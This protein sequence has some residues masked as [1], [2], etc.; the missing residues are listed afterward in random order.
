[1][2]LMRSKTA[3]A[4]CVGLL[5]A[6][7]TA[8]SA[9][10]VALETVVTPTTAHSLRNGK[11]SYPV[12]VQCASPIGATPC[13][14]SELC[15]LNRIHYSSGEA[16]G[17]CFS[18]VTVGPVAELPTCQSLLAGGGG[19]G[20]VMGKQGRG[21]FCTLGNQVATL[22]YALSVAER[23]AK[24]PTPTPVAVKYAAGNRHANNRGRGHA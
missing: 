12:R 10:D 6:L 14:A 7:A 15:V 11:G 16:V 17:R 1:M 4:V 20:H 13:G 18:I 23:N 2:A 8:T 22:K 5:L 21:D 19:M 3:A 9:S 24:L